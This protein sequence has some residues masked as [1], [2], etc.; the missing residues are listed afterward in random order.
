MTRSAISVLL[1]LAVPPARSAEPNHLTET[2]QQQGW[3]L[4]FDGKTTAGWEEITGKP[5]PNCWTI[6]DGS[7]KSLV[8]AT[9]FQDI[10]T[11]ES[12]H[13]FDLQFDWKALKAG[14][15]GVK[16]LIQ[17]VDEW[18]NAAGRQARARGLE[19]QVADDADP[20]AASDPRRTAASLYS[21]IAPKPRISPTTG[22]FNHSRILVQGTHVEHWLN[23]AKVVEF[24]TAGAEVQRLLRSNL[25]TG[26]APDAP[27]SQDSPISLQNHSSEVWFRNIKIRVLQ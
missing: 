9:G 27:L 2:E 3:R 8:S 5:F 11:T 21:L 17:K 19:Y 10:R 12:F 6:D 18:T 7:L 25:P 20:D 1:L 26:S 16:Y 23:G 24:D 4:L 14:N 15:S 22:E 13:S